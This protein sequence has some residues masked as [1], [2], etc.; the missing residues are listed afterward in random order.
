[1][2]SHSEVLGIRTKMYEFW[3]DII[4]SVTLCMILILRGVNYIGLF[5]SFLEEKKEKLNSVYFS[6]G[7]VSIFTND[8]RG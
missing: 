5:I 7:I 2:H 4:L 8:K 1:M 6:F 3:E